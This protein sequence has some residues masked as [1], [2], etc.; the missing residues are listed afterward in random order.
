MFVW[1]LPYRRVLANGVSL[2]HTVL[3]TWFLTGWLVWILVRAKPW[4]YQ[5][6]KLYLISLFVMLLVNLFLG[7]CPLTA[8]ERSLEN[9]SGEQLEKG[10]GF[11][12]ES[13][14]KIGLHPPAGLIMIGGWVVFAMV[15][16]LVLVEGRY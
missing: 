16:S 9:L 10:P 1:L 8:L 2:L 13:L 6:A 3:S 12:A 5:F 4:A 7:Q 14:S 11:L 15:L